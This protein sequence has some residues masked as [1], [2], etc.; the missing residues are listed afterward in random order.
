MKSVYDALEPIVSS[1]LTEKEKG[2]KYEA[3]C[4]WYLN[5]DPFWSRHFSRVGT[6]AQALTWED[7]PIHDTQDTGID[8]VAQTAAGGYWC[9]IQCKCYDSHKNLPKGVCDSFF[10]YALTQGC[11]DDLMVM[12]TAAGP[13][14]N[15]QKQIE[16]SGCMFVDTQKMAA[17]NL[18]WTPFIEGKPAQERVTYDLRPHQEDA[19]FQIEQAWAD[20]DRCKAVMACGTGKTLMSLRLV[21]DWMQDNPGT[22]LFCAPSISLVGQSMREWMAQSRV[23]LSPL[24]VCSDSKASR[25][26]DAIP[27][28]LSDFEYPATTK[29]RAWR[30][31]TRPAAPPTSRASWRS[32]QPTSPSTSST[33]PRSS[34]CPRST[35]S[36]A[37]RRT[38]PRAT[39]CPASAWRR[40]RP[41]CGSTT[42]R[43]CA[44]TNACT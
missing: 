19:V 27:M 14:S 10:A 41:S 42:T 35:S 2:D 20:H 39:R 28:T 21:E 7:C 15:L 44:R 18:D 32:S 26:D 4:V 13:G 24:V 12:T 38:G 25:L 3:A 23:P 9:A 22:V 17:S 34:A 11:V 31:P 29:P 43:T 8:L 37:M 5:N 36:C 30:G 16:G 40:P 1:S 6:L 33:A